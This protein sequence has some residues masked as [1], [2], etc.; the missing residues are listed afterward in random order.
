MA[1]AEDVR[2]SDRKVHG[3]TPTEGGL[4]RRHRAS[5]MRTERNEGPTWALIIKYAKIWRRHTAHMAA[6]L[7]GAKTK[8][9]I[10]H[11]ID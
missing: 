5:P 7:H 3:A 10:P 9:I 6:R 11:R 2:T 8:V 4:R 1:A